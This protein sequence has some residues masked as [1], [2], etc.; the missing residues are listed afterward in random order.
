MADCLRGE[1]LYSEKRVRDFVF[2]AVEDLRPAL[3]SRPLLVQFTREAT[4]RARQR[5]NL[6][7]FTFDKWNAAA[8]A[9]FNAMVSAGTL[10]TDDDAPIQPDI[11]AGAT[12][13]TSVRDDFRDL[14]EAYML[15]VLIRRL[16]DV[17]PRDH[18]A[19]AHA[20]FRQ[21]DPSV[22]VEHLED[23]VVILLARLDGRVELSGHTYASREVRTA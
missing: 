10:L 1:R 11:T 15:E 19:L 14:V 20:L 22:P 4:A 12:P 5:A 18:T 13:V 7:G 17:T 21:F 6:A 8:A 3:D 23:R 2:A 16:G 9:V